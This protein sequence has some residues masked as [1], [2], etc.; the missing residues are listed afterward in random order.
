MH[1]LLEFKQVVAYAWEEYPHRSHLMSKG[2]GM[3]EAEFHHIDK[4]KETDMRW[5]PL[6][7]VRYRPDIIY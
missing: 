1:V 7:M 5:V 6:G 4:V 2:Q 3:G